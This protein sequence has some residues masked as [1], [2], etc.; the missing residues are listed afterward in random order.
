[1]RRILVWWHRYVGL[2]LAVFLLVSGLTGSLLAWNDELEAL[3]SPQLFLATPPTPAARPL[4]PLVLREQVA[5]LYPATFVPR[6]PLQIE[7]G[8]SVMFR[9]YA[10]PDPRSGKTPELAVDQVFVDPYSGRIL[11]TRKYGDLGQ[12]LV[13]LMPFV[14]DLHDALAMGRTGTVLLGVIALLWSIDCIAAIWLTFPAARASSQGKSW[15]ARW[16]QSWWLRWRGGAYKLS[17]D[18][19]RAGALWLWAMLFVIAWSSVAFNL[20]PAYDGVMKRLLAHQ[21]E[22]SREQLARPVLRP[23]L[24]WQQGLALAR[25]RMNEAAKREGLRIDFE[26][27]LIYDPRYARYSYYVRSDRDVAQRWGIT[28]LHIDARDGSVSPLW[29]PTGA[30]AGNT[31]NTWITALHLT[32]MWGRPFQAFMSFFGLA[33]AMLCVTG[34]W[35]WARKRRGRVQAAFQRAAKA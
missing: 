19:H 12:G 8:K 23:P 32:A 27:M 20:R 14:F 18:L 6:V 21:P 24:D 13:N 34:A 28:S 33:L 16:R 2:V 17:F 3:L 9:L 30:A 25:A 10:L 5:R 15:L 35:I 31:F 4:D 7:P 1:M 26:Y 29:Y 11:G 22:P